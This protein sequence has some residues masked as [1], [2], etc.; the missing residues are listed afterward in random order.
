MKIIFLDIDGVLNHS[1]TSKNKLQ[2]KSIIVIDM[3]DEQGIAEI[4]IEPDCIAVLNELVD[5]SEAKL[6]L[7]SS[8]FHLFGLEKTE[9]ILKLGGL[10]HDLFNHTPRKLSSNRH[11][12]ISFY[13]AEHPK[14]TSYVILDDLPKDNFYKHKDKVVQTFMQKSEEEGGFQSKHLKEALVIL[15]K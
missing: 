14:V 1:E 10:K 6:V 7:S 2:N 5:K 8:W 11:H 12:E 13:L 9:R 3:N 4:M 15:N